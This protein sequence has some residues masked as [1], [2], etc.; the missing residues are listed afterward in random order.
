MGPVFPPVPELRVTVV[1]C[2]RSQLSLR[3]GRVSELPLNSQPLALTLTPAD[4]D[5]GRK[6]E[7]TELTHS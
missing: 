7:N 1:K 4:Y 2:S 5:C 3:K 6:P